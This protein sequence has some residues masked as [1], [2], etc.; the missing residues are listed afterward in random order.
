MLGFSILLRGYSNGIFY[1]C[2]H[3][4]LH[5]KYRTFKCSQVFWEGIFPRHSLCTAMILVMILTQ[6]SNRRSLR[7]VDFEWKTNSS[8]FI[9]FIFD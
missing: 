3:G 6:L 1:Y 9:L 2:R 7:F 8:P 5:S 4:S